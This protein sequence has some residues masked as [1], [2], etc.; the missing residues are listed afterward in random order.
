[1]ARARDGDGRAFVEIVRRHDRGLRRLAYRLLGDR[2]MMDDVLQD[3]Y[4][5][6]FAA[7]RDFRGHASPRTWLYRIVYNACI[8]C[9]RRRRPPSASPFRP[10]A[11]P[12]PSENA[13]LRL[14]LADALAALP[15][16]ERAAVL[17]VGV[18][19][20]SYEAAA[21]VIGVAPGTI[22]SRLSRARA[23]LRRALCE[24]EGVPG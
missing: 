4:L 1:M 17:L 5:S 2:E 15:A 12:D 6:A 23:A 22:G 16:E 8:D 3:A 20:L 21:S 18:E 19:G 9:L 10:A 13:D 11:T 24:P 14:T 7:L